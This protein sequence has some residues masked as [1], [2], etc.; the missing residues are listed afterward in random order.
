MPMAECWELQSLLRHCSF[1]APKSGVKTRLPGE[2]LKLGPRCGS[3]VSG[4]QLVDHIRS[5][6]G[7]IRQTIW[8][9]FMGIGQPLVV[10]AKSPQ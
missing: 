9:T 3:S 4:E 7:H 8:T 6:D 5:G 1:E 2:S 10:Q